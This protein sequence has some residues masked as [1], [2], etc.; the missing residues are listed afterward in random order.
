M[1]IPNMEYQLVNPTTQVAL[2]ARCVGSCI[3]IRSITWNIYQGSMNTTTNTSRW[4]LFPQMPVRQNVW[5]FGNKQYFCR[6]EIFCQHIS[7]ANTSNFTATRQLFLFNPRISLW[8]FEVVYTFASE[9]S[10]SALNFMINQPPSNGS[11]SINPLNGTTSTLFT[12]SCID[13]FDEDGISDY[14]VYGK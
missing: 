14:S 2:F 11:C 13:W 5:F 7:G 1:C 10:S 12:V 3:D 9:R 6:M 8:K 4:I